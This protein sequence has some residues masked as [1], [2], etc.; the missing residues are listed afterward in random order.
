MKCANAARGKTFADNFIRR[1]RDQRADSRPKD[2]AQGDADPAR[3]R[4]PVVD[5]RIY[6]FA[7]G[8]ES[9][10]ASVPRDF[11]LDRVHLVHVHGAAARAFRSDRPAIAGAPGRARDARKIKSS[12]RKIESEPDGHLEQM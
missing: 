11:V 8:I 9:A 4:A 1:A 2:E 10:G 6:F 5:F 12:S 3:A 7:A